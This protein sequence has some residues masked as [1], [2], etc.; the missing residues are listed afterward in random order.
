MHKLKE[1]L[2]LLLAY[3]S[4]SRLL[5]HVTNFTQLD[6]LVQHTKLSMEYFL[7]FMKCWTCFISTTHKHLFKLSWCERFWGL[8]SMLKWCHQW[9][10]VVDCI[11]NSFDEHYEYIL[12]AYNCNT[13]T[14]VLSH[15]LFLM[16]DDGHQQPECARFT[17]ASGSTKFRWMFLY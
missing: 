17:R 14:I 6:S 10:S 8:L 1:L 5:L 3:H 9:L 7:R 13:T 2:L 16:S 4:D 12:Y 11:Q 15:H